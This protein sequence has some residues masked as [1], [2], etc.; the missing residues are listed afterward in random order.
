MAHAKRTKCGGTE[1][2]GRARPTAS[3]RLLSAL[4]GGTEEG[5]KEQRKGA[6]KEQGKG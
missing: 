3:A 5:R 6:R 1:E 4:E 2:K